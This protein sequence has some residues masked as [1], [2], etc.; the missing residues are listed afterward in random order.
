MAPSRRKGANKAAAAAAAACRQWKV[1]DLVLAKV[2]GFQPWPAAVSEP[3]KWGYATDWKK[4]LVY[5]FGTQQI[6]FCNPADVEAFTEEKK[7]SLLGR[8]HGKGADFVRAVHEIIESYEKLKKQDHVNNA[9]ATIE[10]AP[11]SEDNLGELLNK[12]YPNGETS[13]TT[14]QLCQKNRPPA[15]EEEDDVNI[16]S[17]SAAAFTGKDGWQDRDMVNSSLVVTE[18]A[19]SHTDSSREIFGSTESQNCFTCRGPPSAQQAGSTSKADSTKH[20]NFISHTRNI[21]ASV[22]RDGFGGRNKRI[23]KSPDVFGCHEVESLDLISNGSIEGN[24]SEILTADSDSLSLNEGST[25]ESECKAIQADTVIE[26]RQRTELSRRLDLQTNGVHKK[27]RMPN[28]KRPNKGAEFTARPDEKIAS[29]ADVVKSEHILHGDQERSTERCLNEDGD[30]HLP[31][32]KRARVRMGRALS[33]QNELATSVDMEKPPEVCDSLS[34]QFHVSCDREGDGTDQNPFP[35]IGEMENSSPPNKYHALK[36]RIWEV[37]KNQHFANSLDGEAA[38]PPSKRLHRA[39][40]AMSANAAEDNQPASDGPSTTKVDT[41][42]CCS[43]FSDDCSKLSLERKSGSGFGASI[44][45]DNENIRN[46]KSHNGAS[47]FSIQSDL[48]IENDMLP[49]AEVVTLYSSDGA[50][51]K[52]SKEEMDSSDGKNLLGS[53]SCDRLDTVVVLECSKSPSTKWAHVNSPGSPGVLLPSHDDGKSESS[54]P[55]EKL[56]NITSQISSNLLSGDN[57]TNLSPHAGT[58]MQK[59][60]ADDNFDETIKLCQMIPEENQQDTGMSKDVEESTLTTRDSSATLCPVPMDVSNGNEDQDQS[61]SNSVSE[62]HSWDK[63]ISV[64][65]PS[66]SMTDG[67]NSV[68]CAVPHTSTCNVSAS[69]NNSVQVNGS[70][71][72][73]FH[74]HPNIPKVAG[75][76]NYKEAHAAL[77][78]FEAILGTLTRTKESIG[79]ATRSAID[80]AKAGVAAKVVEILAYNLEHKSSL[81]RKV[82]L[83]F[84]VDSIAQCSRGLKGD[85]GGIYPSAIL[86]VLPRLLSAAVPPGSSSQ[87]N[88]KQCLKVL[89]VWQERRILPESIVRHHIRE[90]DSFCGSSCP[91]VFSRRSRNERAFD[92]PIRQMEGMLVDEYGSNSSIQLPGFHMPPMLRDGDNGADSDGES[93]EAVTPEHDTRRS[94]GE[95][96][97]IPVVEKHRLVLED[98]DGELEME[99]LA[100]SSKAV[101]PTSNSAGADILQTSIG[102]LVAASFAPPLPKDVPPMLP[103]LPISPPPPP[104]PPLP[105]LPRASFPL[106]SE[107]LDCISNCLSSENVEDDLYNYTAE[108]PITPGVNHTLS[109]DVRCSTHSRIDFHS[110]VPKQIPNSTNCSFSN[111]SVS[112]PPICAVNNIP[113]ADGAFN[114]SFCLRPPHPASSNQFSYVQADQRVQSHRDIPPPSHPNRFHLQ[115]TENGNF[116]RDRDS[117]KLASCDIGEHWRTPPPFLGP[118]YPEGS[119]MPYAPAPYA[120]QLGEPAL[121]SNPWAFP[122]RAMNHRTL[123]PHRPP[124]GGPIPVAARGP[125]CWR[126]R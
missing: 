103:P 52:S 114:N 113:L 27:K 8:R 61:C 51:H 59:D 80:C 88:R 63:T 48:P 66:S 120:G 89:R 1:G 90:L 26:L 28:R 19:L 92:D 72:P 98:V 4:V 9:T 108:Q 10:H 39:L 18:M 94:D 37:R 40:E 16:N 53:S 67:L 7:Q 34:D 110:Q 105:L 44:A 124:A 77:T 100:P 104:P 117:M 42:G 11:V 21:T 91:R 74:S 93:F 35:A 84:L 20:Q 32:V 12:V 76:W 58:N 119:R 50:K 73:S 29:D 79:R 95:M 123:M 69:V 31:L 54:K 45:E 2:K 46:R 55:S 86:A 121:P 41:S 65:Q 97:P 64:T 36:D 71:S 14:F 22:L 30:E 96:K 68:V 47:E 25:V 15:A 56:D 33:T 60:S 3:E 81:H 126:P 107:R 13:A 49:S 75:K 5:F 57:I 82:D 23:R 115:N 78:S 85:V 106:P 125:N 116:Y 38:L 17:E 62:D 112:L 43:S 118:R 24:N 87:E 111:P 122:P 102:T 83:F 101:M 6:A 70:C 109:D 99:D